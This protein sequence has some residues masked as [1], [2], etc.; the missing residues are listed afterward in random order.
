MSSAGFIVELESHKT[1]LKSCYNYETAY[2]FLQ[3]VNVICCNDAGNIFTCWI[4]SWLL[5]QTHNLITCPSNQ[6]HVIIF[7]TILILLAHVKGFRFS[8]K[9][10]SGPSVCLTTLLWPAAVWNTHHLPVSYFSNKACG[11]QAVI[12]WKHADE[13][14]QVDGDS[15]VDELMNTLTNKQMQKGFDQAFM[16]QS[17]FCS[18]QIHI[19]LRFC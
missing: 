3:C 8:S 18:L 2:L 10:L 5:S 15:S 6:T 4:K 1:D 11:H 14:E 17:V 13:A 7:D 12:Y 16:E 9:P 19:L